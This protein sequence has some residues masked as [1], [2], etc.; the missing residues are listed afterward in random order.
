MNN[1]TVQFT[2]RGG[3]PA[4]LAESVSIYL[5]LPSQNVGPD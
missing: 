5:V 4:D 3:A 2:G 1:W